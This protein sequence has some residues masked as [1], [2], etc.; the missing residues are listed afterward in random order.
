MN[1]SILSGGVFEVLESYTT[2]IDITVGDAVRPALPD[3]P[4][5]GEGC[6]NGGFP[7]LI[8]ADVLEKDD[9]S[10]SMHSD[11]SLQSRGKDQDFLTF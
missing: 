6:D 8:R 3:I 1:A 4:K 5:C 7:K 2:G 9:V 10:D 11:L